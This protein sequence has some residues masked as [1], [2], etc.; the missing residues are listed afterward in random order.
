MILARAI[1][2]NG[3]V[4]RFPLVIS[5]RRVVLARCVTALCA[6]GVYPRRVSIASAT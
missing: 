6:I 1:R 3:L 2:S 5:A 4:N